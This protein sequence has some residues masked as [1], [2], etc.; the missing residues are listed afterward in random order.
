MMEE[1]SQQTDVSYRSSIF[2][3][4]IL[5]IFVF[6]SQLFEIPNH[7]RGAEFGLT[8]SLASGSVFIVFLLVHL[9]LVVAQYSTIAPSRSV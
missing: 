9:S 7:I 8:L 5:W 1:Y 4:T 3:L 6:L 2:S